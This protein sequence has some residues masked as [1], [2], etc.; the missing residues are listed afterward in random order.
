VNNDLEETVKWLVDEVKRLR[1][2]FANNYPE[3]KITPRYVKE[4]VSFVQM[5]EM[6]DEDNSLRAMKAEWIDKNIYIQ[7]IL[8][9]FTLVD[10]FRTCE[11]NIRDVMSENHWLIYRP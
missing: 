4:H 1:D 11:M 3:Y 8:G 2:A 9:I 7:K 10:D 5:I 6:L